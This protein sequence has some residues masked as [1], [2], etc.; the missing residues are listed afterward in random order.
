[1]SEA[2]SIQL[3]SLETSTPSSLYLSRGLVSLDRSSSIEGSTHHSLDSMPFGILPREKY[4]GVSVRLRIRLHSLV[5][6]G[7]SYTLTLT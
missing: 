6:L 1:V 2:R 3:Y 4:Y 7:V 5:Y